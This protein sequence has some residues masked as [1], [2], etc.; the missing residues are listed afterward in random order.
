MFLILYRPNGDIQSLTYYTAKD[1]PELPENGLLFDE[2]PIPEE[3]LF[4]IGYVWNGQLCVRDPK[5]D[6]DHMWSQDDGWV[7]D[8]EKARATQWVKIKT[9][10]E[11]HEAAG[12]NFLGKTI[13]SDYLSQNR[14][15]LN[16]AR[17]QRQPSTQFE[18]LAKD[19]ESLHLDSVDMIQMAEDM[20]TFLA[21]SHNRAQILRKKLEDAV[22]LE[23]IRAVTWDS[24]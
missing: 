23:Q 7:P 2:L 11:L 15:M 3:K 8:V 9:D 22:K 19:N 5:P 4:R 10:R 6:N 13:A 12:F 17:A 21:E 1:A 14:I 18:W 20:T 24:V 16:A